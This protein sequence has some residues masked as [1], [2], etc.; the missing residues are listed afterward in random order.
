MQIIIFLN[1][2]PKFALYTHYKARKRRLN[3]FG[4]TKNWPSGCGKRLKNINGAN[5]EG[6]DGRGRPEPPKGG[7]AV[8]T[9]P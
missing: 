6:V 3:R 8:T 9:I 1:V 5:I 7:E 4:Y 2:I